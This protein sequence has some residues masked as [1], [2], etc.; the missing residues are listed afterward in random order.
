MFT[1]SEL[2]VVLDDMFSWSSELKTLLEEL[3]GYIGLRESF[4]KYSK[5]IPMSAIDFS[6]CEHMG[7]RV[8]QWVAVWC[9]VLQ[10]VAACCGV[11]QCVAVCC[12]VDPCVTETSCNTLR[13]TATHCNTLQHTAT[14]CNTLQH[15][16]THCNTMAQGT[17]YHQTMGWL[18]LV[19]S[20]K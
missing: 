4:T 7:R 2:A 15:T 9:S 19:G 6:N 16:A 10:C 8:L 17:G 20:L 18:R 3:K 13:H 11:M 14:H 5:N 12:G 1:A